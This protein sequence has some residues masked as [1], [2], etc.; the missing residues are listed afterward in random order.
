[1][2]MKGKCLS[3]F[4]T[5][6]QPHSTKNDRGKKTS[7]NAPEGYKRDGMNV[8]EV[9]GSIRKVIKGSVS[10]TVKKFLNLN[11]HLARSVP[12][13]SGVISIKFQMTFS[14]SVLETNQACPGSWAWEWGEVR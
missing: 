5:W 4:R 2:T 14:F 11:I 6:R 10:F 13:I 12:Y 8:L 9:K 3:Q 1:M 7:R